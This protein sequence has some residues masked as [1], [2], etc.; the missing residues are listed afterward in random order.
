MSRAAI[1]VYRVDDLHHQPRL[2]ASLCDVARQ[3][4]AQLLILP[5]EI[6]HTHEGEL[7]QVAGISGALKLLKCLGL[8]FRR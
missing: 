5:C 3:Q 4:G 1:L 7:R 2:S 6:A 8:G